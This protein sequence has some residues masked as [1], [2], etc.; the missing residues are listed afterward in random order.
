MLTQKTGLNGRMYNF[1]VA[2]DTT[3]ARNMENTHKYRMKKH[4]MV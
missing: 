4:N 2:Y 1:S 3:F